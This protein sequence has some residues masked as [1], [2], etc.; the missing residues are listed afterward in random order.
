MIVIED[1]YR[2]NKDQGGGQN[3]KRVK[4]QMLA[5]KII[6]TDCKPQTYFLGLEKIRCI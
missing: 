4:C 5:M 2:N 3:F 1:I 6:L